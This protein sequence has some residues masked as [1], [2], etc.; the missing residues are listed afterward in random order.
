MS[1]VKAIA[2]V[3]ELTKDSTDDYYLRPSILGT[4]YDDDIVQRLK[5]K[6]IATENV[7]GKAFVKVFH[8]ECLQAVNENYNVVTD[9]F[10]A[11]IGFNGVVYAKDLGHNVPAKQVHAHVALTQGEYAREALKHLTVSV[12]EQPAP[13]GPVIQRVTNPTA[14]LADTLDTGAMALIQGMR[15]AVRGEK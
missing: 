12:A 8:R 15:L 9:M 11:T 14:G 3:N 10:H 1:T 2:H 6:E 5:E 13:I 4:L 7:N